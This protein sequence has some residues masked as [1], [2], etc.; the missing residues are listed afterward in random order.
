M[1]VTRRVFLGRSASVGLTLAFCTSEPARAA[2]R[3]FEPNAY[4]RITPDNR[5]IFFMTR[6]EMGQ[7]VRTLL[8]T[9]LAEE[10]EVDPNSVTLEQAVP[11]ERFKGIRLRTSGSGSSSGVFRT[12]RP[13]AAAAREMLTAAAAET[14]NVE[15]SA[16]RAAQGSVVHESSGRKLSYGDLTDA[17]ARQAVP[18]H[19]K[20]KPP[21]DF[22]LIGKP[23]RR[24]DGP[25]IV[26]GKATY[27][28]DIRVP[29]M[30]VAVIAR[31]PYLHGKIASFDATGAMAYPGV[32]HVV[33]V[34]SGIFGGI[35]VVADH[36]WAASKGRDALRVEWDRGPY[37]G[38][39]STDFIQTLRVASSE[40]GYPVRREGDWGAGLSAAENRLEAIYEYP[41][42]AHAPLEPMNCTADVRE[43]SC[44]VWVP[45]QTPETALQNIVKTLGLGPE[46]I[47]IHTTLLGGGFGRRLQVDYV[48]EAVEIS[49]AIG[50]PV[51][52]VWTREDDMRNGFFQPASIEKMS[53]GLTGGRIGAWVHKSVGSDLS[54]LE[55][56]TAE[57][58]KD[59]RHYAKAEVPWGAFDTFYNFPMKVDYVPVDS[60][61]PTGPWRAVMY[62]SRVFARES[63]LD[64]VAH[65]LG[66]DALELRIALLQPGDTIKLES[67]EIDRSRMIRVL[68]ET[69]ERSGWNNSLA[70]SRRPDRLVGRGLAVNVYDT[71]SYM[72]QVAEVSVAKDLSD[73]RI[74]R[75]VCVFDCG[76]PLNPAGLEGQ[77]ESGITWGLSAVLHGKINFQQGRVAES[78]YHGFRVMRMDEVPVIETHILP[79]TAGFGGF[80]EHPVAPVAP[81]VA[82]AIFAAIGKRIRRLPITPSELRA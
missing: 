29:G 73:V 72:S 75:I 58:K 12:L 4:I 3:F 49:R 19:P 46:A 55:P 30:L 38:F 56:L 37:A 67:Q 65:A 78:G 43:D 60:P 25:A 59:P 11:G 27:G 62:P 79:S 47:H 17:A 20:L 71:D 6:S 69:R 80:G 68:E 76:R 9:I 70:A 48:D 16:C 39:N 53:A 45:T 81:A 36:T 28:M 1:N 66:R 77:V 63:F 2:A 18:S 44:E 54:M 52:V 64:E 34:R 5:I 26:Q 74:E 51:Q 21:S 31:C 13:A 32:R 33:P 10:L 15:P 57:A 82:N 35:A 8:A 50:K 7:G 24:V 40:E 23:Q 22:R 61:V 42:Q 14:W 41:F